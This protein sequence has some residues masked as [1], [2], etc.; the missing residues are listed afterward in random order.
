MAVR[1]LVQTMMTPTSKPVIPLFLD[2]V[3]LDAGVRYYVPLDF[4]RYPHT[5]VMG[6]TGSGKSFCC[7]ILLGKISLYLSNTAK[8]TVCDY[9]K[10]DEFEFLKGCA[11]YY[12]FMECEQ[13]LEDFFRE[14]QARQQGKDSSRD[15]R[16]LLF[17]EF[18]SYINN[19]PEKK[20]IDEEKAKFA[21]LLLLGRSFNCHVLLGIQRPD[22]S[23]FSAGA[24]DQFSTVVAL[25]NLTK[26]AA[27]MFGFDRELMQPVYQRERGAGYLLQGG[28]NLTA[29][30]VPRIRDM[31]KLHAA[32]RRL[33]I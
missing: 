16:L 20:K 7:L 11:H 4:E 22:A 2:R 3:M 17:D 10:S 29:I 25:G 19:I 8:A 27:G 9:K 12:S 31:E 21:T 32:I 26:E 6:V 1:Y 13:G 5:L 14:F 30:Q 18:S 28:T 33:V 24:R 15:F 23:Y